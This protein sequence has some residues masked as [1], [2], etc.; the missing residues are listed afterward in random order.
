LLCQKGTEKGNPSAL[1]DPQFMQAF[2]A[3]AKLAGRYRRPARTVAR[4]KP[5]KLDELRRA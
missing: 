4:L 5:E 3:R 2:Q 1:F